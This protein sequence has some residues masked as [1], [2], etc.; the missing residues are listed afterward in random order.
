MNPLYG[1]AYIDSGNIWYKTISLTGFR[2]CTTIGHPLKNAVYFLF[3]LPYVMTKVSKP[4]NIA[5]TLVFFLAILSTGS[6][7]AFVI[8]ILS[9]IS[10]YY[11]FQMNTVKKIKTTIALFV[12]VTICSIIVIYSPAGNTLKNRFSTAGDSTKLRIHSIQLSQTLIKE[13]FFMGDGMGNSFTKSMEMLGEFSGAGFENPWLMLVSDVGFITSFL[14]FCIIFMVFKEN[15]SHMTIDTLSK[16]SLI[17][18]M[19]FVLMCSIFNSF[20]T[21]NTLNFLLWFIIAIIYKDN[22]ST[23]VNIQSRE[24]IDFKF[25]S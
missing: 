14:Y 2:V 11:N 9:I 25:F 15:R 1:Q 7:A 17:A 3:A 12:L 24:E 6:R 21:R 13:N 10:M 8:S 16:Y 20:G 22:P 4:Y 19:S 18:F 5:L 23:K